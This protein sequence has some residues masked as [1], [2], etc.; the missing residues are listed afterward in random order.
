M[1][2]L[3]LLSNPIN[4]LTVWLMV[5]F[6]GVAGHMFLELLGVT[7]ATKSNRALPAGLSSNQYPDVPQEQMMDAQVVSAQSSYDAMMS[8][9]GNQQVIL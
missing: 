7:A 3:K 5:L 9:G 4:W 8:Y 1:L 6:V 2:N